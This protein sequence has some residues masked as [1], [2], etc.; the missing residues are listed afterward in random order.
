[1]TEDELKYFERTLDNREKRLNKAEAE[2]H[3]FAREILERERAVT[4][5]EKALK[6]EQ[7]KAGSIDCLFDA[8]NS[9]EHKLVGVPVDVYRS[10]ETMMLLAITTREG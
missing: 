2:L 3:E 8:I 6:E 5:K 10:K 9:S 7:E 1:M 4:A